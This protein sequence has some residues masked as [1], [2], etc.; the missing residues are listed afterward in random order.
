MN[1]PLKML[2]IVWYGIVEV[3]E[4]EGVLQ[5]AI[6]F[7]FGHLYG[8]GA[9]ELITKSYPRMLNCVYGRTTSFSSVQYNPLEFLSS[10]GKY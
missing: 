1:I 3:G 2:I 8:L 7:Q 10:V 6:N 9:A 4:D 5:Q